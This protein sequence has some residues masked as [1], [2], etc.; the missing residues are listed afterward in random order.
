MN[1]CGSA[2]K[3]QLC[4]HAL[5]HHLTPT[6]YLP[7]FKGN[8]HNRNAEK[9]KKRHTVCAVYFIGH[10]HTPYIK[11]IVGM[12]LKLQGTKVH[13]TQDHSKSW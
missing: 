6:P 11:M 2:K 8:Y 13:F 9:L 1:R 5:S 12:V 7:L 10:Y 3:V 4:L